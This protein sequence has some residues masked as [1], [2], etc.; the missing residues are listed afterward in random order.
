[1]NVTLAIGSIAFF[2]VAI[3][4]LVG[5]LLTVTLRNVFHSALALVMTLFGVAAIY[6]LLE[7]EFLAVVQILIYVGA[8]SVLFLFSI[9]LTRS[10]MRNPDSGANAQWAWALIAVLGL[11][12]GMTLIILQGP[13][14]VNN[15]SITTDLL[16]VLGTLLLTT[17]LLPFEVVSVLLLAALIGTFIIARD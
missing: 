16:P 9:M 15:I 3:V 5:G 2:I 10:L 11:L 12:F 4:T 8:I 7:A 6:V 13:W 1:M 17:Y 14:P